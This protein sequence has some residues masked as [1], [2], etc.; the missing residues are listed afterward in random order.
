M[1]DFEKRMLRPVLVNQLETFLQAILLISC[2]ERH[3]WTPHS[4]VDEPDIGQFIGNFD[5]PS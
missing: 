3:L 4:Y 2:F 5:R 1:N